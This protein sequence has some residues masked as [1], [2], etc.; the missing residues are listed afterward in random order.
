MIMTAE[1][2][3][4]LGII[5]GSGLYD[6]EE[7]KNTEW[8]NIES[9][10]GKP[11]DAILHGNLSSLEVRFLPRH[12]RGHFL[13]PSD[14]NF[15]ANIDALKRSGVTD[16][17]SLSAVG[18]LKEEFPPGSFVLVDQYIDRT[19]LRDTSFFGKGCVAHVSFAHPTSRQL[20]KIISKACKQSDI[21]LHEGGTYLAM[22]GPQFSTLAES[23]LYRSWGC[24]VIGMTNL[25]E[26]KL[27]R[28]AEI[29]YSSLAMVTDYDCWHP[30]HEA[31]TVEQ[32]INVLTENA[33][34]AKT[35]LKL[36]AKLLSNSNW[37]WNDPIYKALE[38][39][40]ITVPE[41]RDPKLIKKLDSILSRFLTMEDK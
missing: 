15:K 35:L 34:K 21:T 3:P 29:G 39:A 30:A 40:I 32:I 37:N 19:F 27:S 16:I 6:L 23:H 28:E 1:K 7:I 8:K 20:D 10:F 4:I 41:K 11:S 22:E 5:G 31:V 17:L 14:I 18:S 36:L 25:P 12:G 2:K 13:S 24:S 26:A 33:D 9:P 38:N